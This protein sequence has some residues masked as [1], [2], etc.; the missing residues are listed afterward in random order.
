[1]ILSCGTYL[2]RFIRRN[3]ERRMNR[4]STYEQ[5]VG[6]RDDISITQYGLKI[7]VDAPDYA[8]FVAQMKWRERKFV[9]VFIADTANEATEHLLQVHEFAFKRY[10]AYA[11]PKRQ[12]DR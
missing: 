12:P 4:G 1:M 6:P 3:S 8:S 7:P 11:V 9:R 5:N 10:D 2:S